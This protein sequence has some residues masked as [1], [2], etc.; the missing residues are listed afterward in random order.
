M[1]KIHSSFGRASAPFNTGASGFSIHGQRTRNSKARLV[2][3]IGQ[4]GDKLF[5]NLY[6]PLAKPKL[7]QLAASSAWADHL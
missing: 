4:G 5:S 3:Q 2:S 6:L 7:G 1:A